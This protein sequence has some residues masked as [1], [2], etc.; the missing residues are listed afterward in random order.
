MWL[1]RFPGGSRYADLYTCHGREYQTVGLI[2]L[3]YMNDNPRYR[4]EYR[5]ENRNRY[6][7]L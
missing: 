1:S 2:N 4:N 3:E 5:N 6:E 7:D